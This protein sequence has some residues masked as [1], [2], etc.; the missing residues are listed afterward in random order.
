MAEQ[1][2]GGYIYFLDF[3]DLETGFYLLSED[4]FPKSEN[5][6]FFFIFSARFLLFAQLKSVL[7]DSPFTGKQFLPTLHSKRKLPYGQAKSEHLIFNPIN[8]VGSN[9]SVSPIYNQ[10]HPVQIICGAWIFK[11]EARSNKSY[12]IHRKG[13]CYFNCIIFLF[14]ITFLHS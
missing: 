8:E 3:N 9:S 12:A 10:S 5:R 2:K 6:L 1:E 14:L 11:P 13:G 7:G 4:G